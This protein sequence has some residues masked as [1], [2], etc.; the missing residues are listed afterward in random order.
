MS[1][2]SPLLG[3]YAHYTTARLKALAIR[4]FEAHSTLVFL[5]HTVFIVRYDGILDGF[6]CRVHKI[7]AEYGIQKDHLDPDTL[8]FW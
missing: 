4:F 5:L 6:F 1:T 3:K 7:V 8:N 2:D